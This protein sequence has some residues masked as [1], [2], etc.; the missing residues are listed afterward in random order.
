MGGDIGGIAQVVGRV[1]GFAAGQALFG[2]GG[3]GG[4]VPAGPSEAAQRA[5]QEAEAERRRQAEARRLKTQRAEEARL[6]EQGRQKA[7][8]GQSAAAAPAGQLGQDL[9]G[10]PRIAAAGLK[11]KLGE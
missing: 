7:R 9:L 4:E 8:L 11:S 1:M 3:G 5:E 2:G 10:A 6:L